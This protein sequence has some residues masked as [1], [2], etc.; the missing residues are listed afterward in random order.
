[1]AADDVLSALL[2]PIE[3]ALDHR[4]DALS[5]LLLFLGAQHFTFILLAREHL[6]VLDQFLFRNVPV[7]IGVDLLELAL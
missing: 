4:L 2:Y 7:V 3:E 5:K 6:H 1:M